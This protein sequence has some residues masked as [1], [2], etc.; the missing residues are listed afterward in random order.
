MLRDAIDAVDA[1][2][3]ALLNERAQLAID[4]GHDQARGWARLYF[5]PSARRRCCNVQPR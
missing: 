5:A 4:V 2:L 1:R 3:I